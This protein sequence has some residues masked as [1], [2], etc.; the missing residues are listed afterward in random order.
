MSF[1]LGWIGLWSQ[2]QLAMQLR[3]VHFLRILQ[4]WG[5]TAKGPILLALPQDSMWSPKQ[6]NNFFRRQSDSSLLVGHIIDPRPG[7]RTLSINPFVP[8]ITHWYTIHNHYSKLFPSTTCRKMDD[9]LRDAIA[10]LQ[11]CFPGSENTG[12]NCYCEVLV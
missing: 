12:S 9:L 3:A 5:K 10:N 6:N 2:K 1:W 8:C 11:T 7:L 4:W